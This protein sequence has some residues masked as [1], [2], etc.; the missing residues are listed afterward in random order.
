[1]SYFSTC[2]EPNSFTNTPLES[3]QIMFR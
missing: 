3:G 1:M 2:V